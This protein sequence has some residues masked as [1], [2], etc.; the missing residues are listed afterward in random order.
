MRRASG[1]SQHEL[2]HRCHINPGL[3]GQI[4]RGHKDFGLAT[5]LPLARGLKTTVAELFVGIA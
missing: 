2:A 4:E 5:L 3:L 1:L